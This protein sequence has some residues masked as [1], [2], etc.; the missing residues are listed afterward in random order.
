MVVA[1]GS[2]FQGGH[3]AVYNFDNNFEVFKRNCNHFLSVCLL[4]TKCD[5]ST[6]TSC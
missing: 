1:L 6:C 5:P 3:L 2:S 4:V